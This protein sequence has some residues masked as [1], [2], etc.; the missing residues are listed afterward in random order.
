MK[1]IKLET[2]TIYQLV[3]RFAE[4]GI[5]QDQA[6]LYDEYGK[7][8]RLFGQMTDVDN[9][10][11]ARG[12]EA[13]LSLMNLYN[14]A[15]IQ[16]RLQAAKWS[17]GVALVEARKVIQTISESGWM[18]QAGEAGMTLENLDDGTFKPD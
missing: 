3:D 13:R 17:I 2:M 15:N 18:P 12:K 11:R 16:V 5:A 6:L 10:L 8:N 14:H 9:E 4:I 7:F 1:L